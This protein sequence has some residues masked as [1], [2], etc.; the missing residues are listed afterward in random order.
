MDW[1]VIPLAISM[2]RWRTAN[3]GAAACAVTIRDHPRIGLDWIGI[4][5]AAAEAARRLGEMDEEGN[6]RSKWEWA[7]GV[8]AHQLMEL[9]DRHCKTGGLV[10]CDARSRTDDRTGDERRKSSW[11]WHWRRR[12]QE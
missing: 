7:N 3:H 2:Q 10:P 11:A 1:D 5:W 6:K 4:C 9:D 12:A 8:G